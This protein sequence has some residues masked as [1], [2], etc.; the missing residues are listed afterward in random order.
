[1]WVSRMM[2]IT[3]SRS[4][5]MLFVNRYSD[6]YNFDQ[7]LLYAEGTRF[8]PE[9][10][11]ASQKFAHEKGLPVLKHHLTP[12]TKGFTA[13]LPHL[14]GK[15][16]AIYDIQ[17]A[18]KPTEIVKPT[19]TNLL[20]GE[21][22]EAHMY[23]NRIPLKDVPEGDEAAAAWLHEVYQKKVSRRIPISY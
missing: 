7:L 15:V 13:S 10:H 21:K 9:K 6:V 19:M 2:K 20:L 3:F 1:M 5:I 12:R 8:T 4:E 22:V 16:G 14:R 11:E 17:L 23:I 18:F